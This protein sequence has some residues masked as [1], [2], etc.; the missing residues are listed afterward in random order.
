MNPPITDT[1]PDTLSD[2][3]TVAL[4]DLAKVEADPRYAVAMKDWHRPYST[5]RCNVCLA[6]AVM[7]KSLGCPIA[8]IDPYE[9]GQ[10]IKT[11]L[12]VLNSLRQGFVGYACEE[13]SES[14]ERVPEQ[15]RFVEVPEYAH[16]DFVPTLRAL[17]AS[18]KEAGL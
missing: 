3:L 7:A 1:L 11:K 4:D 6:G 17:A 2:L 5:G 13:L 18:L 12:H 15:L 14:F 8:R 16:P 10:Q 9:L